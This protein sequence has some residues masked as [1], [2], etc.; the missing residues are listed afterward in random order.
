MRVKLNPEICPLTPQ[1][2]PTVCGLFFAFVF[3][4]GG[5]VGD[6]NTIDGQWKSGDDDMMLDEISIIGL[7]TSRRAPYL[8]GDAPSDLPAVYSR[9]GPGPSVRLGQ[10]HSSVRELTC[11]RAYRKERTH[12][13][14][15]KEISEWSR[16]TTRLSGVPSFPFILQCRPDALCCRIAAAIW[17]VIM[18][19]GE[20]GTSFQKLD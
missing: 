3:A 13:R 14:H 12:R 5:G 15:R 8:N 18:R 20:S 16:H 17:G 6:P 10:R 9:N 19:M 1:E 2:R 11:L 7:Q 4:G